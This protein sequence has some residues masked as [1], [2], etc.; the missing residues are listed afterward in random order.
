MDVCLIVFIIVSL[1]AT[2]ANGGKNSKRIDEREYTF[3]EYITH[4]RL[5]T[6]A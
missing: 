4:C 3:R 1:S 2:P 6:L 5:Q